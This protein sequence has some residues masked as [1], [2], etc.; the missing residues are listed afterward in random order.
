MIQILE[1]WH[2]EEAMF[3]FEP[4]EIHYALE[5]AM[6]LLE[7]RV[8]HE[9][10]RALFIM[11]ELGVEA[12][13]AEGSVAVSALH[14]VGHVSLANVTAECPLYVSL[15][16]IASL[17]NEPT[18]RFYLFDILHFGLI[19]SALRAGIVAIEP[20][21]NALAAEQSLAI[22]TIP[23]HRVNLTDIAFE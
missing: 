12:A 22:Q 6:D 20:G 16:K 5:A 9:A 23:L 4:S 2:F 13:L 15:L 21:V 14:W 19:V 18:K 8:Y 10:M 7:F 17:V 11:D 1:V 3:A